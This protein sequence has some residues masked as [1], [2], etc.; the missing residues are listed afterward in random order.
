IDVMRLSAVWPQLNEMPANVADRLETEARYAVYLDRQRAEVAILK[1]EEA[2][3][4]PAGLDLT[5]LSGLS[6][7]LKHKLAAR[8]PRSIADAQRLDGMTPAA[9]AVILAAIQE[10]ERRNRSAA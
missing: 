7:E 9:L 5:G 3:E 2:R 6:N 8:P 1:R 10:H 4:I